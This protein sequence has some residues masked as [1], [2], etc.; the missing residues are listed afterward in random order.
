MEMFKLLILCFIIG[1]AVVGSI[2]FI[3]AV[4]WDPGQ[5]KREWIMEEFEEEEPVVAVMSD[6]E[7]EIIK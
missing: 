6:D 4:L 2:G 1:I 5:T 3:V 7:C